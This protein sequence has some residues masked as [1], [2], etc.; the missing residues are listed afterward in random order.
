M[1]ERCHEEMTILNNIVVGVKLPILI[2]WTSLSVLSVV[3]V[4]R[5]DAAI[6]LDR[7]LGQFTE[8]QRSKSVFYSAGKLD[9]LYEQL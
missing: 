3:G 5:R 8:K 1:S 2:R 7:E 6:W 4:P 9:S